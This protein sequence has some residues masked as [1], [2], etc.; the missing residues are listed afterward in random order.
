[1]IV[2]VG[3]N[4]ETAPVAVREA[5][6]F[7][8]D[9]LP[10]A[11]ARVREEAGLAEAVIL[12]TCNRV[13]VYG[14]AAGARRSTPWPAFLARYS[15]PR[16]GRHRPAPL[17]P[18]GRGGRAPRLPRRREPRLDGAWAR[19]RSSGQ[20]KERLRGGGEGGQ[21]GFGP[22]RAAQP[23]DRGGEAR[24]Q[25]DRHR[26]QR[27]VGLARRRR[28][29]AQD[30]RRAARPHRPARRRGEDERAGRAADGARRRARHRAR[31][32]HVREGRA[33][34][35]RARRPRGAVRGASQRARAG[36]HRHQRHGCARR[37]D[38]PAGCRSGAGRAPWT[39][40]CS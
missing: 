14:R 18:R 35:G 6:A 38:P 25:R 34:R 9:A 5:L 29:R 13:E 12:S 20:V 8:K 36:R 3:V 39:A 23:L 4:H 10:E 15:R 22:E 16:A 11:L 37:R 33:A 26:A 7:P 1:M 40:A 27:R 24:A 2:V 30:L 21:P 32:A 31:R 28:A 17:S 19:R